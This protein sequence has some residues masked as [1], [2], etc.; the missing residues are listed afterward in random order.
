MTIIRQDLFESAPKGWI[1]VT[2]LKCRQK[3]FVLP[4]V[5]VNVDNDTTECNL[6]KLE[7]DLD[8]SY[9]SILLAEYDSFKIFHEDADIFCVSCPD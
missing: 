2:N 7:L 6:C 3:D 8:E 5:Y 4:E 9:S 1:S